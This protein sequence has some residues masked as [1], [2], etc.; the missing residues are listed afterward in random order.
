VLTVL[1]TQDAQVS[2][3]VLKAELIGIPSL[4]ELPT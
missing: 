1:S 2:K 4:S 3:A